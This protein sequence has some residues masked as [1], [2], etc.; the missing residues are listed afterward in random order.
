M[1]EMSQES[2]THELGHEAG[3]AFHIGFEVEGK[4]LQEFLTRWDIGRTFQY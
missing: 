3:L 4:N 1:Q 2:E